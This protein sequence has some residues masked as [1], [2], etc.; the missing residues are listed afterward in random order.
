MKIE[1]LRD[2]DSKVASWQ[3]HVLCGSTDLLKSITC[4]LRESL[5]LDTKMQT[6]GWDHL[7]VKQSG[8]VPSYLFDFPLGRQFF[9]YTI[10][11]GNKA[12]YH[13]F[14][15]CILNAKIR[16]IIIFMF[17]AWPGYLHRIE[18]EHVPNC[19]TS[20][21]WFLSMFVQTI[22][23]LFSFKK[24]SLG[25]GRSSVQKCKQVTNRSKVEI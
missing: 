10:D 14:S 21:S 4:P 20:R 11:V 22:L 19:L 23:L 8:R 24:D 1:P 15:Y 5:H 2:F 6:G 7:P 25:P 17:S 13:C 12:L 16:I 3:A 18:Q 9:T